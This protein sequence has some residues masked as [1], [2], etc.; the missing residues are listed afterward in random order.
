MAAPAIPHLPLGNDISNPTAWSNFTAWATNMTRHAPSLEEIGAAGRGMFR[1]LGSYLPLTD[2]LHDQA[3]NAMDLLRFTTTDSDTYADGGPASESTVGGPLSHASRLTLDGARGLGSVFSYATSR[4]ALS[5]IVMAI[6]LNRTQIFAATRRRLRLRWKLR[7]ILRIL[8][9]ILLVVDA[10][11]LLQS[12]QCQTSPDFSQ[13]RWG[14]ATKTSDLMFANSNHVL[15]TISSILLA[16]ASDEG[17]CISVGMV[18]NPS[19]AEPVSLRG[20]LS[21][22]WPLFGSFCLSHF[23]ETIA[24]AVQG[25]PLATETGMTLFEQSLAFAEADATVN[26]QISHVTFASPSKA[27]SAT[28]VSGVASSFTKSMVLRRVNTAPEVLLIAFLSTMTHISSHVLGVFDLQSKYRLLNTGFWGVCF[29]S[30]IVWSAFVFDLEDPTTQG[31][32]RFPTVCIIGFVP[33]VLVLLGIALCLFIYGL[34]LLL[35]A[36]ASPPPNEERVGMSFRQRIW[37]AHENMQANVSLSEVRITR[38][39]D[40]YTALLRTGFAAISMASEAVY[41]NED[42]GVN[43]KRHTWL[44]EA[45]Y[46]EAEE[47][48]KQWIGPGVANSRFDEIGAIGL[49][50]VKPGATPAPNGYARERAAQKVP[51]SRHERNLRMGVGTT[52]RS[53]RWVMAV[54]FLARIARLVLKVGALV[55]LGMLKL[56][57]IRSQP[58]WLLWL[59]R[60]PKPS[61]AE[62]ESKYAATLSSRRRLNQ[63]SEARLMESI[64]GI[65]VGAEIRRANQYPDEEH[66]QAD[67]WRYFKE[68]G[69]WGSGDTSGDYVPEPTDDLWD[70][71]SFVSMSTTT[72][73]E[74]TDDEA[75]WESEASGQRTPTQRSQ[76]F[77]RENT[78]VAD[79]PMDT[80]A[81]AKLLRPSTKEEREEAATL[82]AHFQSDKIMTR[83]N[84]RRLEQLRRTRVLTSPARRRQSMASPG[85]RQVKLTPDEEEKLLE[86]LLL[87]R[88]QDAQANASAREDLPGSSSAIDDDQSPQCVVCQSASRAI[89]VWP[90]RCLS[91][92]DDCRVSL[93]MNNFDKC[94]CCRRDVLSFSRIYVP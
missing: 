89:I 54:D 56:V 91:L 37:Y 86:L 31:L 57:R 17:S 9:I 21:A 15:N 34:A 12:I 13:L 48:Q 88:R 28:T 8:P 44:E 35:S 51:K 16:G 87:E 85:P 77:S 41:L 90:C 83:A 79:S 46:Q 4:W 71:T 52:E 53:S 80:N 24:C 36:F 50:P 29:M 11:R 78:P 84:F 68:G 49:I 3:N 58:G 32:L 38:D 18:P 70:T 61:A 5:C 7:L 23:I 93:A 47:L 55:I 2:S 74:T 25:R 81:L 40:F 39:M 66:Y 75:G 92:C 26:N 14:N 19:S 62:E 76:R 30:S 20:S 33:H 22:L 45:R 69:P 94:V 64:E 67:I 60:H 59:A 10:R 6:V 73:Y 27:A 63:A 43:L 1:K 42:R 65:D 72:G 82:A